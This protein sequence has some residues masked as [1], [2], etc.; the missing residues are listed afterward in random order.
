MDRG[1]AGV[2]QQVDSGGHTIFGNRN[3]PPI[4]E[5]LSVTPAEASA[6]RSGVAA[7]DRVESG[8]HGRLIK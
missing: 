6:S 3:K 5:Q 1:P 4:D 8:G 2:L 7:T